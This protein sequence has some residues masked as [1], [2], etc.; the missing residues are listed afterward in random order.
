[1]PTSVHDVP[2]LEAWLEQ[3]AAEG[4]YPEWT[5]STVSLL[6][7]DEPHQCRYLLEPYVKDCEG[8][9]PPQDMRLLYK[10]HGWEYVERLHKQ[11]FLFRSTRPDATDMHSD[12]ELQVMM[13]E[14]IPE[15]MKKSQRQQNIGYLLILAV[16]FL[17]LI[18]ATGQQ[19]SWDVE[20]LSGW[21]RLQICLPLGLISISQFTTIFA[22]ACGAFASWDWSLIMKR[23]RR[24]QQQLLAGQVKREPLDPYYRVRKILVLIALTYIIPWWFCT[25]WGDNI[26]LDGRFPTSELSQ[27]YLHLSELEE[28][29]VTDY[30]TL[31]GTPNAWD[32]SRNLAKAEYALLA[33]VYYTADQHLYSTE[34]GD[35]VGTSPDRTS[36]ALYSPTLDAAYYHLLI[37]AMARS[38]AEAQLELFRLV[39]LRWVYE[40]VDVPSTDFVILAEVDGGHDVWQ[41]AA[42]A[43]G[44]K[45]AVYR[46]AGEQ[47]LRNHLELLA[48]FV[49]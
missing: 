49:Q 42:V 5:T 23:F 7:E 24:Y 2:N 18:F 17:L 9:E 35:Y 13:L 11:F 29:E 28:A 43:K 26:G 32:K 47:R 38:V 27:P 22:L 40:D 25:V 19:P 1:M 3:C 16:A 20:N 45:V 15:S 6:R 44:G 37:P 34:K 30:N 12:P 31:F 14:Q 10:E 36:G 33:P 39:N 21:E 8:G 41:M 4:L 48:A 46:Y